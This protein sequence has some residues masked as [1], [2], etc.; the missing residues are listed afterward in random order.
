MLSVIMLS[1]IM[2]SV[3]MLSVVMLNVAAPLVT[4]ISSSQKTSNFK[5]L[6][7]SKSLTIQPS[8]NF[9]TGSVCIFSWYKLPYI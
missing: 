8:N 2:L 3:I 9:S 1:V 4:T 6:K 7:Q 5:V